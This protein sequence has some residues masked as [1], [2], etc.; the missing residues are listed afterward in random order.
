MSEEPQKKK[1]KLEAQKAAAATKK[2]KYK[3]TENG[4][5]IE[6]SSPINQD[7]LVNLVAQYGTT[8]KELEFYFHNEGEAAQISFTQ[9]FKFPNLESLEFHYCSLDVFTLV[10]APKLK[11]LS[12]EQCTDSLEFIKFRLPSLEHLSFD[13]IT[14]NDPSD[15]GDSLSNSPLLETVFAYKLWGLGDSLGKKTVYLPNCTDLNFWRSD[16]ISSLKIYAPRLQSLNLRACYSMK[17]LSF[18]KR[19]KK[20]HAAWNL[21]SPLKPTSFTINVVNSGIQ[22]NCR[23]FIKSHPRVSFIT[24]RAEDDCMFMCDSDPQSDR[25]DERDQWN[26]D[27]DKEMW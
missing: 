5:I 18:G 7:E 25:D 26:S 16:D 13:F 4:K 19:G 11:S 2:P 20:E 24:W 21:K 10:N 9:D 12:F 3:V 17:N 6:V 14:I 27:Y 15:F 1:R 22:G 8:I 23:K